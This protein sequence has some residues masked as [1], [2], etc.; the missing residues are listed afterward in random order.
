MAAGSAGTKEPADTV[1]KRCWSCG[2]M[3]RSQMGG[4][5]TTGANKQL[6][7]ML[8]AGC[9]GIKGLADPGAAGARRRPEP[10]NH[11][12]AVRDRRPRLMYCS[13]RVRLQNERGCSS[14]APRTGTFQRTAPR[15]DRSC[16][17]VIYSI[18]AKAASLA[19][20]AA[21]RQMQDRCCGLQ[22][23]TG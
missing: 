10:P 15:A 2:H 9:A 14:N 6:H 7:V 13:E 18:Y 16:E 11:D 21:G 3:R 23:A 17:S 20:D 12:A 4:D 1:R 19:V 22:A 5:C 8:T